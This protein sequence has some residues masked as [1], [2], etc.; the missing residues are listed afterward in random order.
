MKIES[1]TYTIEKLME[2]A[3]GVIALG[4]LWVAFASLGQ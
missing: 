2:A 1:V 4:F 3:M